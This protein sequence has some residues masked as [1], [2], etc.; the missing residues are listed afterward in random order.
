MYAL[1]LLL[2]EILRQLK[3][4]LFAAD[5]AGERMK[6][7]LAAVVPLDSVLQHLFTSAS[8]VHLRPIR[9][10]GLGDHQ[11]NAGAAPRHHG[12]N[13]ADTEER[14]SRQFLVGSFA[15]CPSDGTHWA[16]RAHSLGLSE[17]MLARWMAGKARRVMVWLGLRAGAA[18]HANIRSISTHL[19]GTRRCLT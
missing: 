16:F 4:T 14:R 18:E 17:D 12:R 7:A 19:N 1:W 8:D 15:C 9:H 3:G 5:I 2:L 13:M 10:K 11:T 6:A